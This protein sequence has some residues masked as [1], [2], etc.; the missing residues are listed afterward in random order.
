MLPGHY[1]R[2]PPELHVSNGSLATPRHLK[3]RAYGFSAAERAFLT[4]VLDHE[5]GWRAYGFTFELVPQ[6]AARDF[7]MHLTHAKRMEELY[8][9]VALAGMSVT[10][11]SGVRP[12]VHLNA[13]NW[14]EPPARSG[15]DTS[16]RGVAGYRT[17]VINHE[18]GHVLGLNHARCAGRDRPAPVMMQQTRGTRE[19]FPEP[20]V[21]KQ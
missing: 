11:R 16:A 20:W 1:R 6:S 13:Q 18:V 8:P 21:V 5:R 15:Y 12:V 14:Y 9:Q 17:Y 7:D 10:D 2:A 4:R 3:F 19:C